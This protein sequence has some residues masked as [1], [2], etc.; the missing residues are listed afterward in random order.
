MLA[1]SYREVRGG[2]T[3]RVAD[4]TINLGKKRGGK[5]IFFRRGERDLGGLSL[6]GRKLKKWRLILDPQAISTIY[7]PYA[8]SV[9]S[10]AGVERNKSTRKDIRYPRRK[11][12]SRLAARGEK[13]QGSPAHMVR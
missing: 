13:R 2:K 6:R 10:S 8:D 3:P 12:G 4:N 9:C 7:R 11:R 5:S 1:L